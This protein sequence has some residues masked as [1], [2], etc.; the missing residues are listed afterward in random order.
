M[1]G[2]LGSVNGKKTPNSHKE[3]SCRGCNAPLQGQNL[4]RVKK[5]DLEMQYAFGAHLIRP[6][7]LDHVC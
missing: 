2:S 3:G 7:V 5:H 6:A 1:E 4:H